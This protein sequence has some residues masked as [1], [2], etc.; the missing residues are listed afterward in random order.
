MYD[1]IVVG[2]GPAGLTAAVYGLRAGKTVL[3]LEKGAF[4]GQVTFSP[5]IE[6]YPGMTQVSGTE[7]AD[8]MVEQA[9][10][11]GADVEVEEVLEIKNNGDFKT[12]VTDMGEHT[13]KTVI[14]ATGA[15]HRRLGVEGEEKFI[16]EGI[17]FC[18]VCDGAFYTDKEV[19]VIGGGNS[20]L[21]EALSLSE[22]CK[23]VTIVQNLAFLTGEGRLAE[24]VEKKE[25]IEV[26]LSHTVERVLGDDAFEGIIIKSENGERELKVDGMFVAIGLAPATKPFEN[27]TALDKWGYITADESCTTDT[28]GIFVAGDC[29][30]KAIRQISTAASDGAIA[31][32][33][34]VKYIER[35]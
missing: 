22:I 13:A 14:I 27:V 30:T 12:V 1:I 19:A 31:A 8:K 33:A 17:S 18:A 21:Q 15:A 16:G 24:L 32:L 25:N 2:A 28:D 34:A 11:Q 5:K 35:A 9:L 3:I 10:F 23:K 26:I 7:L 29:R 20:A 6:N 4:G